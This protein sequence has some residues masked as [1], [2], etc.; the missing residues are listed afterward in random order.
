MTDWEGRTPTPEVEDPFVEDNGLIPKIRN[1]PLSWA[2]R[3]NLESMVKKFN[4]QKITDYGDLAKG[5]QMLFELTLYLGDDVNFRKQM[6]VCNS[7]LKEYA[8]AR[9]KFLE[10]DF[11]KHLA[12]GIKVGLGQL[13]Q[14]IITFVSDE[15]KS[16]V[17]KI[18]RDIISGIEAANEK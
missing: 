5:F 14:Q 17:S 9:E 10:V 3:N 1:L 6:S 4:L 16:K 8:T 15:D 11:P 18:F 2:R 12:E 7:I 13:E